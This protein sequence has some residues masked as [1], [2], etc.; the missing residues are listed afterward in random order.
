MTP[1]LCAGGFRFRKVTLCGTVAGRL[2][3]WVTEVTPLAA[4]NP[5][6]PGSHGSRPGAPG[7]RALTLPQPAFLIVIFCVC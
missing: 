1:P 5:E 3:L 6:G 4:G 7:P 2:Q